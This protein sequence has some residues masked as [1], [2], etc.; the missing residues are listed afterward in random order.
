MKKL[1]SLIF[2][3]VL[4]FTAG[5][6]TAGIPVIDAATQVNLM[7]QYAKQVVQYTTQLNELNEAI[8][9]VN[10]LTNTY[11]AVTGNRGLGTLLN[12]SSEQA[13]RRYIPAGYSD[14]TALSGS[15]AVSGYGGLQSSVS[16]IKAGMT[17]IPASTYSGNPEAGAL[18]QSQINSI[19]TQQ[20]LGESAYGAVEGRTTNIE[21]LIAT[22]SLATDPKA[23]AEMQARIGAEQ[24][25]VENE[26]VRVH[27]LSYMQEVEKAK[28]VQAGNDMVANRKNWVWIP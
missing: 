22:T 6:A 15:S 20:A 18:Y 10:Q 23:I 8:N 14:V 26:A 28:Q 17:K 2:A 7:L 12:S 5:S 9:T 1:Y 13:A 3:A 11:K 27:T 25:L 21:N 16:S 19:S 24:A 4:S